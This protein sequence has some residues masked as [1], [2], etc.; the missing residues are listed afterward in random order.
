[1]IEKWRHLHLEDDFLS[2]GGCCSCE[3]AASSLNRQSKFGWTN[4]EIILNW[5]R[6]FVPRGNIWILDSIIRHLIWQIGSWS[7]QNKA[8]RCSI[9]RRFSFDS[10]CE[11]QRQFRMNC[12]R[13][14]SYRYSIEA[15]LFI[16][17]FVSSI[18]KL[19]HCFR[20]AHFTLQLNEARYT[21]MHTIV[22]VSAAK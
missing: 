10:V 11:R 7:R 13:A 5:I 4:A 9:H 18:F 1:M 14:V 15:S 8:L 21:F 20:C 19:F 3:N 22:S 6:L 2:I 16:C 17:V 12:A